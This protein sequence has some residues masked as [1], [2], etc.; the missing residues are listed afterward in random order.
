LDNLLNM[1]TSKSSNREGKS[2]SCHL[3]DYIL[4][5]IYFTTW[6]LGENVSLD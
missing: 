6:Q 2:Y 1:V 5:L 4:K 3:R